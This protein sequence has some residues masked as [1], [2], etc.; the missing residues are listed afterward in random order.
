[1]NID[2]ISGFSFVPFLAEVGDK[3]L[4]YLLGLLVVAVALLLPLMLIVQRSRAAT[5]VGT[6]VTGVIAAAGLVWLIESSFGLTF[7]LRTAELQV[8]DAVTSP[9]V[10]GVVTVAVALVILFRE[11]K[12][13]PK[14][15]LI[16]DGSPTGSSEYI[17]VR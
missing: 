5:M 7:R 10:V 16:H 11:T 14:P 15:P 13:P 2:F 9:F 17:E 4:N 8:A 6:I 1:M 12:R 3:S